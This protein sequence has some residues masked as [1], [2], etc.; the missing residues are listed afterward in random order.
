MPRSTPLSMRLLLAIANVFQPDWLVR[1]LEAASEN[2]EY[3]A[4][5]IGF[6]KTLGCNRL[7]FERAT[8][9]PPNR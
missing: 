9:G 3:D 7:T 4:G 1:I 6:E 2:R 8:Y 5:I